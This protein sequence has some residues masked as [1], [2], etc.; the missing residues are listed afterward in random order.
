MKRIPQ[1]PASP[2]LPRRRFLQGLAAGGVLLGV[3]PW[4]KPSAARRQPRPPPARPRCSPAPSSISR[5]RETP[6]N[7]TGTPRLATTINGSIPG[8]DAALARG[9]YRD[10]ARHQPASPRTPRS[11]GT[12]SCC[13]TRWTACRA[14]AFRGIA[15]GETFTYRFKVAQTGTYWYHSH[16][17]MQE[18]TGMYGAIIIDPARARLDP[19]R[20]RL[21]GAV[22]RLDRRGPACGSWPS[23]R[24]RATTTTS[25]SPRRSISSAMWPSDGLSAALDKREM[26]NQ[27]RMSPTDLADISGLHLHLSHERHH[28]GRQLDRAVPSGREGAAALHQFRRHDVFRRA[29]P[30]A[31]DD[32]GPGRRP[33]R[34]AGDGGRD[35]AW[36]WPR[37]TT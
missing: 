26:W 1:L 33:E 12:A 14:S 6:V 15:P 24:C 27:M 30:G 32:R 37:P 18:Q 13:R 31:Q 28:A 2:D 34:R 17:G 19:R 10:H 20:P 5:S 29:H 22:V 36:A 11:T 4:L 23:S 7:F 16:S 9:R 21:R 3:S 35:S 8:A 25:T